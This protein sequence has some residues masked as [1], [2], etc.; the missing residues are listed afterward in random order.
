[1]KVFFSKLMQMLNAKVAIS[2]RIH[3]LMQ[4]AVNRYQ[5]EDYIGGSDADQPHRLKF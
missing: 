3:M 5:N 4:E 2:P 1:M